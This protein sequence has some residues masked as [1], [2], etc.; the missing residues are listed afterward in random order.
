M[1]SEG[2][3]PITA[4]VRSR[5]DASFAR[6][7]ATSA[8]GRFRMDLAGSLD[9]PEINSGEITQRPVLQTDPF[10]FSINRSNPWSTISPQYAYRLVCQPLDRVLYRAA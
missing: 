7:G 3:T 4:K 2:T 9:S 10:N 1:A 5:S 8:G 6:I